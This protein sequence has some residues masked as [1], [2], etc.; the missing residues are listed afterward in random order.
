MLP[1]FQQTVFIPFLSILLGLSV[2]LG[3]PISMAYSADCTFVEERARVSGTIVFLSFG[4]AI[5]VMLIR[6]VI[7]LE[8]SNFILLLA[9]IRSTSFFALVG[10]K[11]DTKNTV[12]IESLHVTDYKDFFSYIIPWAIFILVGT[13]AWHMIPGDAFPSAVN[14]GTN[15]RF[16]NIALFGLVTGFV[17]DRFGR[18]PS[19]IIG[20][21]VLAFGFSILGVFGISYLSVILYLTASGVTW[22]SFF[23]IYLT[24]PGD[25]SIC[26]SREKLYSLIV[27]LPL[28]LLMSVPFIPGV[29]DFTRYSSSFSQILGFIVVLTIIPV[30]RAKETLPDIKMRERRFKEYVKKVGK[31]VSEFAENE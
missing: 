4:L 24:I 7:S 3:L 20:L 26:G 8:L 5:L 25:L 31:L 16:L 1:I 22:G 29:A 6:N 13:L 18:K 27:V 2:G 23:A 15:L 14:I 12:C 28:L 21:V 9:L 17:A 19:I 10:D 11:F 30:W